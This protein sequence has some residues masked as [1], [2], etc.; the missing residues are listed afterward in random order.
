MNSAIEFITLQIKEG[1]HCI[2]IGDAFCSQIG[3]D[4]YNNFAF[5]RQKKLVDHIHKHGCNCQAS[6]LWRYNIHFAND[7]SNRG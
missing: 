3:P 2:G 6:Y 7:D 1:A 5:G 4:L